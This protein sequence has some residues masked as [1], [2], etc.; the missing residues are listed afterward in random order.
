MKQNS[1]RVLNV[2]HLE[3]KEKD[4]KEL[5]VLQSPC[6]FQKDCYLAREYC[7]VETSLSCQTYKFYSRLQKCETIKE[8]YPLGSPFYAGRGELK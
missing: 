4:L 1:K 5:S 8:D 3:V 6:I 2:G 7:T